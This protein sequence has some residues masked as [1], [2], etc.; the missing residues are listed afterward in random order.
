MFLVS[1][2]RSLP[3]GPC[4]LA[5]KRLPQMQEVVISNLTENKFVG[6]FHILLYLEWNVK[7]CFQK[8]I[9]YY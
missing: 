8:L 5:G 1:V 6:F 3:L 9:L 2:V 4:G 7:N